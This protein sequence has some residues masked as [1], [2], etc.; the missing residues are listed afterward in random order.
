MKNEVDKEFNRLMLCD[1]K[2]KIAEAFIHL[3]SNIRSVTDNVGEDLQ[4]NLHFKELVE[5]KAGQMKGE[6]DAFIDSQSERI[7]NS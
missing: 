2:I 4:I 6:L 5:Q 1:M 3:E 7:I